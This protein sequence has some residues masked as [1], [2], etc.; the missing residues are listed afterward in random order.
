MAILLLREEVYA[1]VGAAMEVHTQLGSG[2][3]EAVYQEALEMELADRAIPFA[4]QQELHIQYKGRQ[5]A[6]KYVADLVC[7]NSVIVELKAQ[8]CLTSRDE[9]QILNY[10]TATRLRVGVLINFGSVGKLEWKRYAR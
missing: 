5:L 3:L 10:L 6:K 1:I 2:F 9:V 8:V 7:Y 4:H